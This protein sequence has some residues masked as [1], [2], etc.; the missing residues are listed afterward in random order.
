LEREKK[1]EEAGWGREKG[2]D[3]SVALMRL[4]EGLKEEG[5]SKWKKGKTVSACEVLYYILGHQIWKRG[6]T[7]KGRRQ[8]K[9]EERKN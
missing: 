4:P 7:T 5:E 8:E 6:K 9:G 1:R 2:I 3:T